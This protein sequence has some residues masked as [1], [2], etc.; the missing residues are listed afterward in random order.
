MG[1]PRFEAALSGKRSDVA[2]V[3]ELTSCDGFTVEAPTGVLG[4]VEETWLD[5]ADHP[6]ALAVRTCDGRRALLP[7]DAVRAVDVDAQEV[8]VAPGT[9]LLELDAPRI[10]SND[11]TV[12]ASWRTTGAV[13]PAAPGEAE[14]EPA[15]ALAASRAATAVRDRPIA[16]T[17]AL[18]LG[19]LAGLIAFEIGLAFFAAYLATGHAY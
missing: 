10:A 17:V 8:L 3:A 1:Q 13:V 18:A 15:P 4:W 11:G 19:F 6:G 2:T 14:A 7:A 9:T 16:Q 5:G 12:A